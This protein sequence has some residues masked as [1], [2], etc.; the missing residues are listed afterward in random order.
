MLKIITTITAI[1]GALLLNGCGAKPEALIKNHDANSLR[2]YV[3]ISNGAGVPSWAANESK[4]FRNALEVAAATT[5]EKK[6]KYF[7]FI[8]PK[9]ISNF[10]GS[11][12]NSAEEIL[13]K[14]S[15]SSL[16][17]LSVPDTGGLH[18]CGTYNTRASLSIVMFNEEQKDF[19]VFNAQEVLDYMKEKDL[20]GALEVNVKQLAS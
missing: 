14:C 12:L 17:A 19:T 1:A 16:L 6:F 15:S 2:A 3:N 13:K 5:L 8:E 7:A 20:Y 11:L 9:E 4:A 18:K 10:D